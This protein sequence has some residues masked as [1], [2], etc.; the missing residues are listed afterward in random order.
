MIRR[1]TRSTRTDTLFPYTTLCR[2]LRYIGRVKAGQVERNR[3]SIELS[4]VRIFQIFRVGQ[5]HE[6]AEREPI[7]AGRGV[8]IEALDA[9]PGDVGDIGD[10]VAVDRLGDVALG[11][12]EIVAIHV[13]R[14][15]PA[16]RPVPPTVFGADFVVGDRKSTRLNSSP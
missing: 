4:G 7:V 8:E 15:Q 10:G 6:A 13:E 11:I 16:Q 1:P 14:D 12:V 5:G 2:S 3:K 9:D